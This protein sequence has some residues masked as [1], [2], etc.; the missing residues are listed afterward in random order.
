MFCL[1]ETVWRWFEDVWKMSCVHWVWQQNTTKLKVNINATSNFIAHVS[2]CHEIMLF[3]I[4][5]GT[6]KNIFPVLTMQFSVASFIV[7]SKGAIL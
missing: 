4:L 2:S 5:L 6:S 1:D 3:V 7:K